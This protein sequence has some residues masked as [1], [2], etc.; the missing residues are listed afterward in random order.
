MPDSHVISGKE[1]FA[2]L[3]LPYGDC[4]IADEATAIGFA[5][6]ERSSDEW[7]RR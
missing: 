7:Q 1:Q 5:A 3:R 2:M 6:I 4:P